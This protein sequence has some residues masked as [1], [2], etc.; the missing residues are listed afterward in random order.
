MSRHDP[1]ERPIVGD[2]V[3]AER[4]DRSRKETERGPDRTLILGFTSHNVFCFINSSVHSFVYA[5]IFH[6][7]QSARVQM[8]AAATVY[9]TKTKPITFALV[10]IYNPVFRGR[11]DTFNMRPFVNSLEAAKADLKS[12]SPSSSSYHPKMTDKNLHM[13]PSNTG[14]VFA[15]NG[16]PYAVAVK[17]DIS[18]YEADKWMKAWVDSAYPCHQQTCVSVISHGSYVLQRAVIDAVGAV[19]TECGFEFSTLEEATNSL[20][21]WEKRVKEI[22]A[23]MAEN[24]KAKQL[25]S[26]SS[27]S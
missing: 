15:P 8:S 5:Y 2:C 11:Y 24:S 10:H 25:A 4:P 22:K 20:V 3:T 6:T 21:E 26:S 12:H 17:L 13:G 16:R 14:C 19:L 23:L 1:G 27:K 7:H 18:E 9:D